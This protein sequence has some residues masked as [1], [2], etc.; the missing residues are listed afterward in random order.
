MGAAKVSM[1]A[2]TGSTHMMEM[3]LAKLAAGSSV[4]GPVLA[5]MVP[6]AI[7]AAGVF[8]LYDLGEALYK[9][10]DMSGE[11]AMEAQKKTADLDES[12]KTLIDDTTLETDKIGAAIAKIEQTPNPNAM[13]E[14]IDQAMVEA[15]KMAR[16]LDG[17]IEKEE[18]LLKSPGMSDSGFKRFVMN[19]P[20]SRQEEVDL[21]QHE[22]HLEK[23]TNL[24]EQ[25]AESKSFVATE[26]TKLND[27]TEKAVALDTLRNTDQYLSLGMT[28]VGVSNL[29][30][31]VQRLQ[32]IVAEHK[33]ETA[34]IQEKIE[35]QK[36]S[37]DLAYV[38][39]TKQIEQE[40]KAGTITHANAQQ[41]ISDAE[42]V[43]AATLS[44]MGSEVSAPPA[45]PPI[46][47]PDA[48]GGRAA[49][50][51]Y[52]EQIAKAQI[53][54]AHAADADLSAQDRIVEEMNKQIALNDLK[55]KF[56]KEGTAAERERLR[57]LED[58]IAVE[59]A[60]ASL[61]K[62]GVEEQK[63]ADA[64]AKKQ[65]A[66]AAKQQD[67]DLEAVDEALV[68]QHKGEVEAAH[69]KAELAIQLAALDFE[70]SEAEIRRAE[71]EGRIS[72]KVAEQKLQDAA[73]LKQE[74]SIA[75]RQEEMGTLKPG[76]YEGDDRAYKKMQDQM[77]LDA[78]KGALEREG[79]AEQ[80]AKKMEQV[81]KRVANEF[82]SDFTRAFNQWATKSQTAGQAFGKML[83]DMELQVV[84]FAAKW[85]LQKVEMWAMSK[86]LDA[87][88]YATQFAIQ[89]SA[90]VA[91]VTSDAGVAAAG[92]MAYYSAINP[93]AAPAMAALQFAETMSYAVMDT[94]GMMPH[95]GFAF[96]K[97]GSAE[98]VLSPS[99]TSNFESLVNNGGSRTAHLHQTNNYGGAPT[100][101][102][103]EAQ[104]AHTIS[105]LKSMLR[106][107]AFA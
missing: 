16:T 2:M 61:D 51:N 74:Q 52:P 11:A 54:A 95:M 50:D 13:K 101:E 49:S 7:F 78:K 79:L 87:T 70:L 45:L 14:A 103:H 71:E 81:Y 60:F 65:L 40:E 12:Y 23:A 76:A 75:A 5:A 42:R 100:K 36:Q 55:A 43:R 63:K 93:P 91:A 10:F 9:A 31:E 6:V 47:E 44:A 29:D 25:L 98:R 24:E 62:L 82:N 41:Q 26:Q 97:S 37:A 35:G 53:D 21:N 56:S 104:T 28:I 3:G 46:K 80:E 102:M 105:R 32:L 94:G 89:K 99:Q 18:T 72:H 20:S 34:A 30:K 84:D 59:K 66:D 57:V 92:A 83:G 19:E 67:K 73:R 33:K 77:V 39:V 48:H 27:L 1:G 8:L 107:E 68:K 85:I 64:E 15:D 58:Q 96:N 17:L 90:N 22:I 4:L 88:G 69:D 38:T 106:P 86:L